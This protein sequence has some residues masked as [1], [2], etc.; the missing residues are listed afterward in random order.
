MDGTQLHSTISHRALRCARHWREGHPCLSPLPRG[1]MHKAEVSKGVSVVGRQ[2]GQCCIP[3]CIH[4]LCNMTRQLQTSRDSTNSPLLESGMAADLL[5]ARRQQPRWP[6]ANSKASSPEPLPG[7]VLGTLEPCPTSPLTS[8]SLL[9]GE[10][11]PGAPSP[12]CSG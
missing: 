2:N 9:R 3:P 12:R 7:C 1:P 6:C 5:S 11:T 4:T 10:E 8:Q